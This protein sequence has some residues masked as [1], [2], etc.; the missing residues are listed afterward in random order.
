[1]Y[2]RYLSTSDCLRNWFTSSVGTHHNL[3]ILLSRTS[4]TWQHMAAMLTWAVRSVWSWGWMYRGGKSEGATI[5]AT[6]CIDI[7]FDAWFSITSFKKFSNASK[8]HRCSTGNN[9]TSRLR[10]YIKSLRFLTP[11]YKIV[12]LYLHN[13]Y[14]RYRIICTIYYKPWLW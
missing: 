7:L 8:V 14:I 13:T 4:V 1:M 6:L 12:S 11:M 2:L 5:I 3:S 10:E 9:N